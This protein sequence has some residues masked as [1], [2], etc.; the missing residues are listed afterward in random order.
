MGFNLFKGF[1]NH[2]SGEYFRCISHSKEDFTFEWKLAPG[3]YVPFEHV[4]LHQDEVFYIK[5]GEVEFIVDGKVFSGKKGDTVIV[6][7]GKPH[8]AYNAADQTVHCIVSYQPALDSYQVF[9]CLAGLTADDLTDAKG[10]VNIPRMCFFISRMNS[11]AITRPTSIPSYLFRLAL[12]LAF[13]T[14]SV[15]GWDRLY[16]KYTE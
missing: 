7:K 4:H 15:L 14:G 8:V 16:R 6:P 5:E 10:Q 12:Q 13:L 1:G 3:G 9:Q 11:R 2:K